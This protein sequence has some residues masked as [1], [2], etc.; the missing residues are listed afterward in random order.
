MSRAKVALNVIPMGGHDRWDPGTWKRQA[1]PSR[2]DSSVRGSVVSGLWSKASLSMVLRWPWAVLLCPSG[3]GLACGCP[4]CGLEY[5]L[6]SSGHRFR[7]SMGIV[8]PRE[9]CQ[10]LMV[11]DCDEDGSC[12]HLCLP[13]RSVPGSQKHSRCSCGPREH[14]AS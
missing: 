6:A 13:C 10:R 4:G 7:Y 1:W 12:G 14:L 9:A 3:P 8:V 2:M 5:A 11:P